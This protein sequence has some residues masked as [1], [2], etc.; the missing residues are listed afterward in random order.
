VSDEEEVLATLADAAGLLL[1]EPQAAISTPPRAASNVNLT[2]RTTL[3]LD[4]AAELMTRCSF[5]SP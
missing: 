2:R 3:N 4:L 1:D 5:R